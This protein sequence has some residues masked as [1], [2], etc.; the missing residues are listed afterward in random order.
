MD[1][2][3]WTG[4]R[5]AEVEDE[6]VVVALAGFVVAGRPPPALD[7]TTTRTR[8][9]GDSRFLL[10]PSFPFFIFL[11]SEVSVASCCLTLTFGRF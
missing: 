6:V 5:R 9:S 11:L 10:L 3:D 7:R 8:V 1:R 4:R 2:G